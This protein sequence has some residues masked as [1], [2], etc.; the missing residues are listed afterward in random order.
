[1]IKPHANGDEVK[2]MCVAFCCRVLWC[3]ILGLSF[4]TRSSFHNTRS[5]EGKGKGCSA[6][7]QNI[8]QSSRIPSVTDV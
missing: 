2:M 4:C 8:S 1:M 7:C 5:V 6:A 3:C